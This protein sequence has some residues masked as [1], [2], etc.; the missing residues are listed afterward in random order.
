M[1]LRVY[2]LFAIM[3]KLGSLS[4]FMSDETK[5]A[6]LATLF[7]EVVCL[8]FVCNYVEMRKCEGV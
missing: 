3:L 1:K 8:Q 5:I 7:D 4:E 2:N 6:L